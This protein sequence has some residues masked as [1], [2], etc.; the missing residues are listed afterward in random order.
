M[1]DALLTHS[2]TIGLRVFSFEKRTLARETLEVDTS[3]GRVPVK[4]VTLPGGSTRWKAE[5]DR[6]LELAQTHGMPYPEAKAVIEF[7]VRAKLTRI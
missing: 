5:H 2:T 3:L 7:E 6:I 1:C 4:R